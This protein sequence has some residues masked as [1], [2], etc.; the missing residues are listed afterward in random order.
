MEENGRRL[1][2]RGRR[3]VGAVLQNGRDGLVG[4]GIEQEGAGAGGVDALCPIALHK[5]E[6]PDG[7]AKALFGMRP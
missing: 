2:R 5:S 7:G 1:L 4:S 3:F 6:N